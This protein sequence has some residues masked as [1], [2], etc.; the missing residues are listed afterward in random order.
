[1][2]DLEATLAITIN[3]DDVDSAMAGIKADIEKGVQATFAKAAQMFGATLGRLGLGGG[4]GGGGAASTGTPGHAGGPSGGATSTGTPSGG[5]GGRSGGPPPAAST[6]SSAASTGGSTSSG[7]ASRPQHG[8]RGSHGYD[9]TAGDVR[10]VVQQGV[11]SPLGLLQE[12]MTLKG[13]NVGGFAGRAMGGAAAAI[14]TMVDGVSA[15]VDVS[16]QFG[17]MARELALSGRAGALNGDGANGVAGVRRAAGVSGGGGVDNYGKPI[18]LIDP[19]GYFQAQHSGHGFSPSEALGNLRSY[20]TGTGLRESNPVDFGSL[21]AA[22]I[23]AGVVGQFRSLKQYGFSDRTTDPT[24]LAGLAQRQGLQ[25]PGVERYLSSIQSH[26]ARLATRGV[27]LDPSAMRGFLAGIEGTPGLEGVGQRGVG[28][29]ESLSQRGMSLGDKMRD[30]HA[31]FAQAYIDQAVMRDA[32]KS[33]G[34][35]LAIYRASM[36]HADPNEGLAALHRAGVGMSD[37]TRTMLGIGALPGM[38]PD[39]ADRMTRPG[40]VIGRGDGMKLP[41]MDTSGVVESRYGES[42]DKW[43]ELSGANQLR[44]LMH[45][46]T[47]QKT[48]AKSDQIGWAWDRWPAML[49][50][51]MDDLGN[52]LFGNTEALER[53]SKALESVRDGK[54]ATDAMLDVIE[55]AVERALK[56][57]RER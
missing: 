27:M 25:G 45:A 13:M 32:S 34:D 23:D 35:A 16:K 37:R 51:G 12:A 5:G 19:W 39:E 3:R 17:A 30:V 53:H 8:R 1:M 31:Q 48:A 10:S 24:D 22:G 6:G 47:S 4:D 33:G 18:D 26:I 9:V 11:K 40:A 55:Q 57:R 42:M 49:T 36:K 28:A 54:I 29:A 52:K 7:P 2:A 20:R 14:G 41:V 56:E 43:M 15:N 46:M 50:S 21:A 44:D 38:T